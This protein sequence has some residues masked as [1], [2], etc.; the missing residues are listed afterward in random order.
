[1]CY[2]KFGT[3][4]ALTGPYEFF[5]QYSYL[6]Q[7]ILK[8]TFCIFTSLNIFYNGYFVMDPKIFYCLG[9]VQLKAKKKRKLS[10]GFVFV[11]K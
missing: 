5:L 10:V 3:D 6:S 7:N 2:G 1:M 9:S 8:V 11:N 4:Y